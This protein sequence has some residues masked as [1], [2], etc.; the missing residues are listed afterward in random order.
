MSQRVPDISDS[1]KDAHDSLSRAP[2]PGQRLYDV[3][4]VG[5]VLGVSAWSVRELI[6]RGDLPH[7]RV[8]RLI[9]VDCKD[10][11][12]YIAKNRQNGV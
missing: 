7:V 10:L 5:V 12:A 6:W 2:L 9:R 4:Q 8:G 1:S 11:E 3:K